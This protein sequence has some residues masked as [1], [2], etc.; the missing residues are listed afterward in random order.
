MASWVNYVEFLPIC[1]I[2][3]FQAV[4]VK[5]FNDIVKTNGVGLTFAS[6]AMTSFMDG[7]AQETN[8][9]GVG[10]IRL[11]PDSSTKWRIPW[12]K[13][14]FHRI[15]FKFYSFLFAS[16]FFILLCSTLPLY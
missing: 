8:L 9:T 2:L 7:P 12:Y 3:C 10:E 4:P 16:I 5:R 15:F 1:C 14:V 11:M 6:M 13:S